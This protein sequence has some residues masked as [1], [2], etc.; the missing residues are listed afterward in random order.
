MSRHRKLT[1]QFAGFPLFKLPTGSF[2][3][4][5][6]FSFTKDLV[7]LDG[8]SLDLQFAADK[9]FSKPS[10]LAAAETQIT[11][12]KGPS[13]VFT[14]GSGATMVGSDG[15]I[16]YGPENLINFSESFA[17]SG[18]SNN[19]W[20]DV[21]FNRTT[22]VA[23]PIGGSTAIRFTT[24]TTNSTVISSAAVGSSELRTFSFWMRRVTGTGIISYTIDGGTTFTTIASTTLPTVWT[25]YSYTAT[26]DHRVGFKSSLNSQAIEIWGVQLERASVARQYI[27]TTTS[28]VFGPRFDHDPVTLASKGLLIEEARTNLVFPSDTLTTQTITVTAVAHT[29]SFYGTG[30]VVLSG[31]AIATV[32]GAGAYPTRTTLTFTPTAGS[33]V[34]TVTGSVVFAQLEIGVFQTSYIPTTTSSLV[35]SADV[36]SITGSSF[37]S[38]YNNSEGTY[39]VTGNIYRSNN[40]ARILGEVTMGSPTIEIGS[41]STTGIPTGTISYRDQTSGSSTATISGFVGGNNYKIAAAYTSGTN[42]LL[43]LNGTLGSTAASALNPPTTLGIYY[44]ATA[45]QPAGHISSVRFYKKRL[46][47]TKLQSITT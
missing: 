20:A 13:P 21:G 25:R 4:P 26:A 14:R 17:T 9:S 24:T 46:P 35:R 27:P 28:R 44:G 1:Q 38:F 42:H 19:N 40:F 41:S 47:N 18:G 39:L 31:V 43:C 45:N 5:L 12:R 22:G 16:Q 6:T 34:L 29:L 30:T 36:C 32:T 10:T 2:T 37:T 15:L 11:S 3:Y 8:L 23:D 7:G 33:L